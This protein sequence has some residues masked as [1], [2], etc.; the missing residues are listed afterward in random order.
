MYEFMLEMIEDI[1]EIENK[2]QFI[3][4]LESIQERFIKKY[5]NKEPFVVSEEDIFI[6]TTATELFCA[7]IKLRE[8]KIM[9]KLDNN[10]RAL[11]VSNL[12]D[13]LF[14]SYDKIDDKR[15]NFYDSDKKFIG[16]FYG[17]SSKLNQFAVKIS[18]IKHISELVDLGLSLNML[19]ASS[20]E[21]LYEKKNYQLTT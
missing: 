14:V 18:K 4:D 12:K 13:W 11:Y 2:K 17:N 8:I 3:L 5:I 6:L 9:L 21:E 20:L 19:Y 10:L 16:S 15:W 7:I 1:D